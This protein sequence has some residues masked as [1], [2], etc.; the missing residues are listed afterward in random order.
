MLRIFI[1]DDHHLFVGPLADTLAQDPDFEVVGTAPT[2]DH[3]RA[4]LRHTVPD[5]LLLD[6]YLNDVRDLSFARELRER[7][8]NLKIVLLSSE[9]RKVHFINEAYALGLAGYLSKS[10]PVSEL[11]QELKKAARG[12]AVYSSEV[13]RTLLPRHASAL[14]K[15][16]NMEKAILERLGLG[17][18]RAAIRQD[19]GIRTGSTYDTH[20][21][22]LKEK[23]GVTSTNELLRKAS[24][25]GYI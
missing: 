21:Q 3:L 16:T 7:L 8:P 13:L 2:A 23:F 25:S 4:A 10:I 22:H 17:M 9:T 6:L 19:L 20:V 24:E 12:E 14:P 18:K 15:L 11:K 1:A 5:L